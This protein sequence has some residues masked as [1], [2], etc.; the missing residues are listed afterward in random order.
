MP[1]SKW[2][3]AR[4]SAG[5]ISALKRNAGMMMDSASMQAIDAFYRA[6]T[7]HCRPYDEKAWFAAL[8]MECLWRKEDH[9]QK[10]PF[11]DLLRAIY[12][13]PDSTES[14]RKR[15][16]SFFDALWSE[17][18]YLLGKIFN[19]VHKMRAE[20]ASVMPDFELLADDLVRWNHSDR[21]IQRK[22]LNTICRTEQAKEELK[23]DTK[24]V[25]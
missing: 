8:C 4:L 25:D 14:T 1:D 17:D 7:V 19:L 21:Y 15:C 24:N 13:N 5:E 20:N 11:P 22:W 6:L 10:K 16:T 23:E 12:Q 2:D 3:L 9:P 18:G